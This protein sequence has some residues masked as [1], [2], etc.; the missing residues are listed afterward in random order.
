MWSVVGISF[1]P[2]LIMCPV[3]LNN[4][5]SFTVVE[6]LAFFKQLVE[7]GHMNRKVT[8]ESLIKYFKVAII[9]YYGLVIYSFVIH[10]AYSH[11][12]CSISKITSKIK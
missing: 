5:Q 1:S 3:H 12:H 11:S 10:Y 7:F 4:L 9:K 8:K 2:I 6:T